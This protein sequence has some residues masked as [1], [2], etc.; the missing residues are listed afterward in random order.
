[1]IEGVSDWLDVMLAGIAASL[2]ASEIAAAPELGFDPS[3]G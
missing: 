3:V 1:M 2:D